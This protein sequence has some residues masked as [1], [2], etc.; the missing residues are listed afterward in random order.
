[1][2]RATN[3]KRPSGWIVHD[4][5]LG[6]IKQMLKIIFAPILDPEFIGSWDELAASDLRFYSSISF[7]KRFKQKQA[8]TTITKSL[9]FGP[10]GF[11]ESRPPSLGIVQQFRRQA[12][13]ER[14]WQ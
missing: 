12:L 1:M 7:G 5:Q 2:P 8:L 10:I 14:D 13:G 11:I 4:H 6:M 9:E 3:V